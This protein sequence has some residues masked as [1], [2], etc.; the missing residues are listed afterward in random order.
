VSAAGGAEF[1][2]QRLRGL[3]PQID[4]TGPLQ[5]RSASRV[6]VQGG[7]TQAPLQPGSL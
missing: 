1:I 4:D 3:E 7:E 5:G 2:R 6:Y